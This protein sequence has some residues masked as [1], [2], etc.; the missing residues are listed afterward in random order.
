[1]TARI[2]SNDNGKTFLQVFQPP[3]LYRGNRVAWYLYANIGGVNHY[4][5]DT[6]KKELASAWNSIKKG[7][8]GYACLDWAWLDNGKVITKEITS[9]KRPFA[10]FSDPK[11]LLI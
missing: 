10:V 7:A 6:D 11:N 8:I 2:I 5:V 1:M 4:F 3:T 9:D